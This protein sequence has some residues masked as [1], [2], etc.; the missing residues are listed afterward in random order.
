MTSEDADLLIHRHLEGALS[1][2]DAAALGLLLRTDPAFRRRLAE[3]AF[4]RA[5]MKD[6][7]SAGATEA[8]PTIAPAPR[9]PR[10]ALL[11][12]AAAAIILASVGIAV[13]AWS[14]R[15]EP[16]GSTSAPAPAPR[17]DA[18][19]PKDPYRGF[20]GAVAGKVL[21]R[22]EAAFTLQ[23]SAVP[24]RPEHPMVGSVIHV[25]GGWTKNGDGEPIPDRAHA[26]F[27]RKLERDREE[28]VDLRHQRDDI[29]AI[30]DLTPAQAEWA[31]RREDPRRKSP[32]RP[33][34]EGTKDGAEREGQPKDRPKDE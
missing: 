27:I 19:P 11:P 20:S 4:E 1:E 26:N 12:M 7:L 25:V 30:G 31:N 17:P 18:D 15:K 29:F 10:R 28:T 33:R 13:A 16:A 3:M 24:G 22:T 34:K 23:V 21:S 14:L 8:V 6:V 9:V 32:E 2:A 5:Q